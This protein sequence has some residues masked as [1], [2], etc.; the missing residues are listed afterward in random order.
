MGFS[1]DSLIQLRPYAFHLT[2]RSNLPHLRRELTLHS[3]L[4]LFQLA[5]REDLASRRRRVSVQLTSAH[6]S[7]DVRDQEPLHSGSIE[8]HGSWNIDD[9]VHHIN[10][11]V[12]FWPGTDAGPI[13]EGRSHYKR[14]RREDPVFL[15][16]STIDLLQINSCLTPLF[17]RFNSGAPRCS[18]GRRSPRGPDSYALADAFSGKV[19]DVKEVVFAGSVVVPEQVQVGSTPTGPWHGLGDVA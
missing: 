12:F 18:R 15:R 13:R 2:S 9:L 7:V 16:L 1:L 14:Y 17:C 8:F 4:K 3:A 11:H 19:S 6:G 5:G 10:Q